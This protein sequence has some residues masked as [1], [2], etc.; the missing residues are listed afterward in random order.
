[1]FRVWS[2]L[3]VFIRHKREAQF[4]KPIFTI[5]L[6]SPG[7]GLCIGQ[8]ILDPVSHSGTL[9]SWGTGGPPSQ[10]DPLRPS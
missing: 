6:E 9:N 7:A 8:W 4:R 10:P 5:D 1:M 3:T 2:E